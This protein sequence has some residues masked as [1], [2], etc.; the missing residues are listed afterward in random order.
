MKLPDVQYR[1]VETLGRHDLGA[2]D[3]MGRAVA[4]EGRMHQQGAAQIASVVGEYRERKE[5][6][7]YNDQVASMQIEF[8]NWQKDFGARDTYSA[9]EVASLG[10]P[11]HL[12]KRTETSTDAAGRQVTM[13]RNSIPAH[14]V[15]PHLLRQKLA[16]MAEDKAEKISNGHLRKEFIRKAKV[17]EA[18]LNMQATMNAVDAQEK[19]DLELGVKRSQDAGDMGQ[20]EEGLFYIDNLKTDDLHKEQLRDDLYYRVEFSEAT[21]A[22]RSNNPDV[23]ATYLSRLNDPQYE[24]DIPENQ[25]QAFV[26]SLNAKLKI[27][28]A[29]RQADIDRQEGIDFVNILERVKNG[30]SSFDEIKE[31]FDK[32]VID[33]DDKDGISDAQYGRLMDVQR[34]YDSSVLVEDRRLEKES[35]RIETAR[36]KAEKEGKVLFDKKY[37]LANS[38]YYSQIE[39]M[40]DDNQIHLPDVER[41]YALYI[42]SLNTGIPNPNSLN[43]DQRTVIRRSIMARDKKMIAETKDFI[44]GK[45]IVEDGAVASRENDAHQKGVDQY[46]KTTQEALGRSLTVQEVV[47]ITQDTNI[48]PDILEDA[49]VH[50]A[51]NLQQGDGIP[52]LAAYGAI[53]ENNKSGLL[54]IN[55]TTRDL[56][57]SAWYY[58]T[59]GMGAQ[60]SLEKANELANM[61]PHVRDENKKTYLRLDAYDDNIAKLQGKMYADSSSLYPF[62]PGVMTSAIGP[63]GQMGADYQLLVRKEFE[64]TGDIDMARETAWNRVSEVW[65]PSGVGV[66]MKGLD[67]DTSTRAEKYGVERTLGITTPVAQDRLAAF[68]AANDLDPNTIIVRGDAYTARGDKENGTSWDIMVIDPETNQ[69][70]KIYNME[71]GQSLRWTP[72]DWAHEGLAYRY[73]KNVEKAKASKA[74]IAASSDQTLFDAEGS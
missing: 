57:D 11:A 40:V 60:E 47:K 70:D 68:A 44:L 36:L 23:V 65:S 6:A 69:Y 42:D 16:G 2:L 62:D 26:Q 1:S 41:D 30:E 22:L 50:S 49:I 20:M 18:N 63:N 72:N 54:D 45:A 73:K 43:E 66:R 46:V 58:H 17:S 8:D 12:V 64:R 28:G 38:I 10:L 4:A 25:R 5:N 53:L 61:Q 24:G 32:W 34:A 27:L 56:M 3:V 14:E 59:S 31:K 55:G 37:K 15:Y 33:P 51:L 7:E 13:D 67:I 19:Y 21:Q 9:E 52:G 35:R 71:T 74:A 39:K 29:D 48:M